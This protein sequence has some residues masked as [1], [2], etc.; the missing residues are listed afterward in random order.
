MTSERIM[1]DQ[2][3]TPGKSNPSVA[4]SSEK[5]H[6]A[7]WPGN[8]DFISEFYSHSRLHHIATWRSE[9]D[10]LVGEL[11]R[12]CNG[13]FPGREHLRILACS[14]DAKGTYETGEVYSEPVIMHVDMDC[15][16]V[17]VALLHRPELRESK[18]LQIERDRD[19][20]RD[21]F[22]CCLLN[23]GIWYYTTQCGVIC[24]KEERVFWNIREVIYSMSMIFG[25][26]RCDKWNTPTAGSRDEIIKRHGEEQDKRE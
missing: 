9:F 7:A 13:V 20:L 12:H 6:Q 17:S 1:T 3:L 15:F 26:C 16:F 19:S 10:A 14:R 2:T 22:S 4:G 5:S 11:R 25:R 8:P 21:S 24:K 23:R 18:H